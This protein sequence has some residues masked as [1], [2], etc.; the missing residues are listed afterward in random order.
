MEDFV[1]QA[2]ITKGKYKGHVLTMFVRIKIT[3]TTI[4]MIANVPEM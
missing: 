4:K 2:L 3:A 1:L